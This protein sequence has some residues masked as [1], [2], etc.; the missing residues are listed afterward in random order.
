MDPQ[1]RSAVWNI[2]LGLLIYGVV[3]LII[4]MSIINSHI[5]RAIKYY[6]SEATVLAVSSALTFIILL[7]IHSI[8]LRTFT[9]IS[10][11]IS[12]LALALT[13]YLDI[14][15][16]KDLYVSIYPLIVT[17]ESNNHFRAVL[18]DLFQI[19]LLALIYINKRHLVSLIR[20]IGGRL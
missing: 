10:L 6:G 20:A 4:Y 16:R 15:S 17:V 5:Y 1:S 9:K 7:V 12:L 2:G 19:S 18:P 3:L 8:I 13:F 11:N 14:F